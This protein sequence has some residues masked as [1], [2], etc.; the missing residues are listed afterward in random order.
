MSAPDEIAK[1][2]LSKAK[3]DSE[4][5]DTD[6][7]KMPDGKEVAQEL[8]DAIDAKDAAG[9]WKAFQ[10]LSA[11]AGDD[12]DGEDSEEQPADDEE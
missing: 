6:E 10:G 7:P 8:I 9:V 11:C 5:S 2:I 4:E 3:K 1:G 12:D